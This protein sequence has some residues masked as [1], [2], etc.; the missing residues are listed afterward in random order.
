M[1]EFE[2]F[3][4][5]QEV[6][7]FMYADY[8]CLVEDINEGAIFPSYNFSL[9][10]FAVLENILLNN[11]KNK[12][13]YGE[14]KDHLYDMID[15]IDE[16]MDIEEYNIGHYQRAISRI[17]TILDCLKPSNFNDLLFKELKNRFQYEKEILMVSKDKY[18]LLIQNLWDSYNMDLENA[19]YLSPTNDIKFYLDDYIQMLYLVYSLSSFLAEYPNLFKNPIVNKRIRYI[20]IR[21][22]NHDF[23]C[24]KESE[25]YL[26]TKSNNLLKKFNHI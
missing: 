11:S 23:N 17:G 20:L 4:I 26:K 16:Y 1:K 7:D 19:I 12:M 6:K 3:I 2:D 14:L 24:D 21:L 8:D 18:E 9:K 5:E 13:I 15:F 10:H 25:L 22:M